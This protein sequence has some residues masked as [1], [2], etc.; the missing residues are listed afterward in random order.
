MSKSYLVNEIYFTI[1]GEGVRYGIPHVF[2]R[3][4]KCN[5]ACG[6]CDTEFES[7]VPMTAAEIVA[8]A[9]NLTRVNTPK[10]T[11]VEGAMSRT[12]TAPGGGAC[13][14]VLFCGGEPFLQLDVELLK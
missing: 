11:V 13:R 8:E 7:G 9:M 12:S 6:F 14:N 5:L 1:H 2:V 3:F 10:E 4:A